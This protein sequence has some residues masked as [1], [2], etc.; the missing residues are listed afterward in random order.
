M[1]YN[2]YIYSMLYINTSGKEL[3]R[4]WQNE[5]ITLFYVNL[6]KCIDECIDHCWIILKLSERDIETLRWNNE[7]EK[8]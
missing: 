7:N 6:C 8:S 4:F 2:L 5:L 3:I 1:N